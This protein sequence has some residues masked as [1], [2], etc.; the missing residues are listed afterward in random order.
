MT[1]LILSACDVKTGRIPN[2]TLG[3]LAIYSPY[4]CT[5]IKRS[6]PKPRKTMYVEHANILIH[7]NHKPNLN[8]NPNH[9]KII[10]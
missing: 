2:W 7:N 9:E 6:A 10:P 3:Q 8:P 1:P 4:V 5:H